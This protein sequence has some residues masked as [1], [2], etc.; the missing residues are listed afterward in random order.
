M[1]VYIISKNPFLADERIIEYD[2]DKV[3]FEKESPFQ[4][5]QIVHTKSVGNMLVLDELQSEYYLLIEIIDCL[6]IYLSLLPIQIWP[7]PT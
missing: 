3:L 6:D 7:R 2:V 4:K 1:Q 5:V